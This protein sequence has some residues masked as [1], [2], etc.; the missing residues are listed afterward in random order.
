[1]LILTWDA[2]LQSSCSYVRQDDPLWSLLHEGVLTTGASIAVSIQAFIIGVAT[3]SNHACATPV[4]AAETLRIA[5]LCSTGNSMPF[6]GDDGLYARGA[7][8][9]PRCLLVSPP[10]FPPIS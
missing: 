7:V 10:S 3:R 1:M 6:A 5:L 2:R 4:A 9:L 8:G